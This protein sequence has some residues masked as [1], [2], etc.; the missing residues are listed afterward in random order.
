MVV[1]K[2]AFRKS[3]YAN[4][5]FVTWNMSI[6]LLLLFVVRGRI[7]LKMKTL[8]GKFISIILELISKSTQQSIKLERI[9]IVRV[10]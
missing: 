7:C 9:G 8:N 10:V 5:G 1:V 2:N 6:S 4:S 3:R